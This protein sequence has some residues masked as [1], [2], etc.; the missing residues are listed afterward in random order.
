MLPPPLC[1]LIE[2]RT[3][4]CLDQRT[5][6]LPAF[7]CYVG[8]MLETEWSV[9]IALGIEHPPDAQI[10]WYHNGLQFPRFFGIVFFS[11]EGVCAVPVLCVCCACTVCVLCLCCVCA[12]LCQLL[13]RPGI[14]PPTYVCNLL[15][16][17]G[18]HL[19][20]RSNPREHEATSRC[21]QSKH[22][23]SHYSLCIDC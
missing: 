11:M 2:E 23:A 15:C 21:A 12:V 5:Q 1:W 14:S 9:G 7:V 20:L 6:S 10:H 13:V 4:P 19:L 3:E 8:V 18:R 17:T 16:V 22:T